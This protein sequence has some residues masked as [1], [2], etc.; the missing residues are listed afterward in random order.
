MAVCGLINILN[1]DII[2]IINENNIILMSTGA[3]GNDFGVGPSTSNGGDNPAGPNNPQPSNSSFGINSDQSNTDGETD[4]GYESDDSSVTI[5]QE[6]Y[7]QNLPAQVQ[8]PPAQA[9]DP[10]SEQ[11]PAEELYEDTVINITAFAQEYLSA[12]VDLNDQQLQEVEDRARE[13]VNKLPDI[14]EKK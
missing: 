13:F 11:D 10:E 12:L 8:N 3:N 14:T 5:T 9:S 7:L 4:D 6:S 2:S 1:I